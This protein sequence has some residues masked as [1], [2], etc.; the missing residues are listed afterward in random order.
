MD[1][2]QRAEGAMT[3]EPFADLGDDCGWNLDPELVASGAE[4]AAPAS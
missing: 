1:E 2:D 3:L 4:D